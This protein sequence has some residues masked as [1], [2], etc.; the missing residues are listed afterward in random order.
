[1]RRQAQTRNLDIV[2][3]D[4][5]FALRAPRNDAGENYAPIAIF[6]SASAFAFI[7]FRARRDFTVILLRYFCIHAFQFARSFAARLEP[8]TLSWPL[9]TTSNRSTSDLR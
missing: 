3:R 2:L 9:I 4:S 6:G 5:G 8:V 7:S 1:M